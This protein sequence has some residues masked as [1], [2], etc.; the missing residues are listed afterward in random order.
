MTNLYK[1]DCEWYDDYDDED[2]SDRCLIF[3][4]SH[5]EAIEKL[6]KNFKYINKI[7]ITEVMTDVQDGVMWLPKK[8]SSLDDIIEANIY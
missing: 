7:H 6:E 3:A 8:V 1:V 4:H 5:S 2:K